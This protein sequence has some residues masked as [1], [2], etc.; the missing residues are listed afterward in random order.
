MKTLHS[1]RNILLKLDGDTLI[2]DGQWGGRITRDQI[3]LIEAKG[4]VNSGEDTWYGAVES[5]A[6]VLKLAK[7]IDQPWVSREEERRAFQQ[8]RGGR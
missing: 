3:A 2:L 1:G 5:Q 8:M 7:L 6:E 4:M